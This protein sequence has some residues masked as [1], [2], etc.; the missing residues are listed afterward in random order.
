MRL[1]IVF[2]FLSIYSLYMFQ[3]SSAYHQE[4]SPL[5]YSLQFSVLLPVCGTVLLGTGF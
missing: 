5:Q 2:Y 4:S 3:A 1:V